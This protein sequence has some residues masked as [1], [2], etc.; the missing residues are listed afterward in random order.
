MTRNNRRIAVTTAGLAVL[1]LGS[2][3]CT[4]FSG[5]LVGGGIGAL[6]TRGHPVGILTG[7]LMGGFVGYENER[8]KS[9]EVIIEHHYH[10]HP[11]TSHHCPPPQPGYYKK[12][13]YYYNRR[14]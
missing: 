10:G 6:A 11:A 13:V 14:R 4:T 7:M 3:G 1:A 8:N 2:A 9:R 5:A 12:E